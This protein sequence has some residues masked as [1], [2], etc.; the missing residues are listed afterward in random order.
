MYQKFFKRLFDIIFSFFGLVLVSPVIAVTAFLVYCFLGKPILFK[1]KRVGYRG[2]IFTIYKFRT[3]K[4]PYTGE[5][6]KPASDEDRLTRFGMFLRRRSLDELPQLFNVLNGSM[7][8][9]GP[10]ALLVEYLDKYTP[11]QYKRHDAK[12]GLTCFPVV[13]G[14]DN[15]SWKEQFALDLRYVREANFFLDLK[16]IFLTCWIILTQKNRKKTKWVRKK[17]AGIES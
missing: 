5:D 13:M 6:G 3:M 7:S 14:L 8:I 17:F 10:R 4:N 15:I 2:K 9:V 12:P 11:E 16:M 1:Q